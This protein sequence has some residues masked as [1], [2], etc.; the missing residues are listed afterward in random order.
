MPLQLDIDLGV[1][2][3]GPQG[4]RGPQGVQGEAGP[5]GDQGIQGP[6]G[7]KGDT[8]AKGETGKIYQPYIA[9]DGNMH[10]KLIN[11]DGS[12]VGSTNI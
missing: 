5:K 10:A 7:P 9:E 4:E 8:G 6:V 3:Q 11:P 12:E 1:K 2:A